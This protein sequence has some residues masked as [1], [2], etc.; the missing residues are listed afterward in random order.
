M[1][2]SFCCPPGSLTLGEGAR[3]AGC[4]EVMLGTRAPESCPNYPGDLRRLQLPSLLPQDLSF[5]K[6]RPRPPAAGKPPSPMS[7]SSC[8]L[9]SALREPLLSGDPLEEGHG[10]SWQCGQVLCPQASTHCFGFCD[11]SWSG[12]VREPLEM[13]RASPCHSELQGA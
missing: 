5:P 7:P 11:H 2:S 10:L 8:P 4:L 12:D 6:P 1:P 3:N 9:L 13:G